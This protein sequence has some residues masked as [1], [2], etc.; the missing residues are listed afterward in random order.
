M[1]QLLGDIL[2]FSIID[3]EKVQYLMTGYEQGKWSSRR[4]MRELDIDRVEF[5]YVKNRLGISP[6]ESPAPHY[7]TQEQQV[8]DREQQVEMASS[9]FEGKPVPPRRWTLSTA[10]IHRM[11][12]SPRRRTV[13]IPIASEVLVGLYRGGL[14]NLLQIPSWEVHMDKV[15]LLETCVRLG[16]H[17]SRLLLNHLPSNIIFHDDHRDEWRILRRYYKE[18]PKRRNFYEDWAS[19]D[20]AIDLED[21]SEREIDTIFL[22]QD[23]SNRMTDSM[24]SRQFVI[25]VEQ[26][27]NTK[28]ITNTR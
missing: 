24:D 16:F 26:L 4:V 8:Q 6:G 3:P 1:E 12:I 10:E 17:E 2:N 27:K 9:F 22:V 20:L 21:D 13:M 14:L 7:W 28:L 23:G 18:L 5:W 15:V 11:I 25:G 19:L